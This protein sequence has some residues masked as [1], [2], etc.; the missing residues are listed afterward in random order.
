MRGIGT[1]SAAALAMAMALGG[2]IAQD[3]PDAPNPP[4]AQAAPVGNPSLSA[5]L[6][7]VKDEQMRRELQLRRLDIAITVRGAIAETVMDMEFAGYGDQLLEGRLLINLPAGAVVTGYALDVDGKIVDGSLV[8]Q[9]RAVAAYE[10]RVRQRVDPGLGEVTREGAFSTRVY[11]ID[12]KQGRRVR[13]SFTAPVR[14]G[15]GWPLRLAADSGEWSI[16][17]RG[18]DARLGGQVLRGEARGRGALAAE[19]MLAPDA[20]P[21][22]ASRHPSTGEISWQLAGT[23]P[24]QLAS[25]GGTMR[26]YWDRS[27]SSLDGDDEAAIQRIREAI[28]DLRPDRIEWVAF[29]SSGAER[30]VVGDADELAARARAVRYGGASS[31]ALLASDERADTCLLVTDG[32]ATI[33]DAAIPRPN[34]CAFA[35]AAAK[36]ADSNAL[37]AMGAEVVELG[38]RPVAWR[39]PR[40]VAVR[41]ANGTPLQFVTLPAADDQWRLAVANPSGRP[42]RVDVG[43]QSVEMSALAAPE[44]FAGEAQLLAAQRLVPLEGSVNREAYVELSRRYGIASPS[45]SYLVLETPQDYVRY[46]VEPGAAYPRLA[47]YRARRSE[48]D[49][50]EADQRADRFGTLL[51]DWQEEIAW[52]EKQHEPNYRQ[53]KDGGNKRGRAVQGTPVNV[54]GAR[55][56]PPPPPPPPPPEPER[57]GGEDIV[58]T[59]S[60]AIELRQSN[61]PEGAVSTREL[62]VTG[63]VRDRRT[64][65]AV[66][67]WMPKR[68]Y[69]A[70]FD[71]D[72]AKFD[73]LFVEWEKKAGGVPS[74]YLDSADWLVRHDRSRQ[75]IETLLSALDLPTANAATL[76]LVAARLERWGQLDLAVALRERQVLLDTNRPQPRRLLALALA[77]RA[78]LGGTNARA[79]LERAIELLTGIALEPIA[80]QWKGIDVISLREANALMPRLE[81]LG[82]KSKLDPRLVR[83]L[84]ADL[85]VVVDWN[86]PATDLDLW[87]D[88][89]SGERAI[90]NN[91]R[92]HM[93]GRLSNDMTNGYGPEDY[94]LRRAPGGSYE[95]RANTFRSDAMDPNGASRITARLIRD[96]GRPTEHEESIDFDLGGDQEKVLKIGTM[97]MGPR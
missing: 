17:V 41:D 88:E 61:V 24:D 91:P 43:G 92:T 65:I 34:C 35:I 38:A 47:E 20:A 11:P 63:T 19:L 5:L 81:S 40:V 8:E 12:S 39:A 36:Q 75:A 45:L 6:R 87:V 71:A 14:A 58:V 29:N 3:R 23:L 54:S 90:Y 93:G 66:D 69:L 53:P 50:E 89:P 4:A 9:A 86:T 21:A 68:E 28:A 13:L 30:A 25:R 31:F 7:G 77:A 52:W 48:A 42:V 46:G 72:P 59:S 70:E 62:I 96:F 76:G 97:R 26:V 94:W 80:D 15:T 27:R 57:D 85:R 74:F 55:N 16:S 1:V 67:A 22:L 18:G 60:D 95:I 10:D 49:E 79:D 84:D 37:Q 83:N 33:G 51:K 78:K 2:A 56:E 32:R 82:G 44:S 73:R 64:R